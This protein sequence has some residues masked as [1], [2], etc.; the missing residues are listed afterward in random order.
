[1]KQIPRRKD[2]KKKEPLK[3]LLNFAEKDDL[4]IGVTS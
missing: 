3:E 2:I 1:M 4:G